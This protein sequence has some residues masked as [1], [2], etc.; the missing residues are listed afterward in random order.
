MNHNV[1]N[2]LN[3][4][5]SENERRVDHLINLVEKE[6]RTERHLEQNSDIS[7]PENIQHAKEVQQNREEEI[8]NLKNILVSGEHSNNNQV[9]NLEKRYEYTN[10]YLEHNKD[11]M[12][13]EALKNTI[14]KQEH[15]KDQLNSM[16]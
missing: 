4:T 9:K 8:D 13:K 7:N 14:E 3:K 11:H 6:T 1:S 5:S 2:N 15:R 10:G 12:D 16:K